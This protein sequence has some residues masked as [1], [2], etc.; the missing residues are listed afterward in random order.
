MNEHKPPN[1]QIVGDHLS[2][3]IRQHIPPRNLREVGVRP[4]PV[5]EFAPKP[6]LPEPELRIEPQPTVVGTRLIEQ[7]EP[8]AMTGT[9][10]LEIADSAMHTVMDAVEEAEARARKLREQG[11]LCIKHL[12]AWSTEFANQHMQLLEQCTTLESSINQAVDVIKQIGTKPAAE[13]DHDA[14]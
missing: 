3:E 9:G 4:A 11:E 10:L 14:G 6:R 1:P 5:S 12:R 13:K 7:P 8:A 2:E